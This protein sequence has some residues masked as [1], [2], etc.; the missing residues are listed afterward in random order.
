MF[1]PR[2]STRAIALASLLCAPLFGALARA[3][4]DERVTTKQRV[5]V[6][7]DDDDGA[8]AS[9]STTIKK[10]EGNDDGDKTTVTKSTRKTIQGE[11]VEAE[12]LEEDGD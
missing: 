6:G 11:D 9:V 10:D 8:N 3:D 2:A 4:D 12:D 1:E 7:E 5:E